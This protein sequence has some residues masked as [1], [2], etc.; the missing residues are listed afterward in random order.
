M[1]VLLE[2]EPEKLP[3]GTYF[4]RLHVYLG[5]DLLFKIMKKLVLLVQ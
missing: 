3:S 4:F 5:V 1:A 2:G